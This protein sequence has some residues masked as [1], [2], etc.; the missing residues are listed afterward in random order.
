MVRIAC[1]AILFDLDGVLIDSTPAVARVWTRWAKAH[2]FD[3]VEVVR[4]AHGR[5]S[6]STIREYL[7]NAA[8]EKENA[9]VE[10]AEL[11]DLEDVVA[12]AG[13]RQLLNSLPRDRWTIV[14]S[15]TRRLAEAR[16]GAAALPLPSRFVTAT[17]VEKG[18]PDPEPYL[19]AAA[20]LG[21]PPSECVVVEDAPSGVRAGKAAGARVIAVPTTAQ[22]E[23][24][25]EAGAEWMVEAVSSISLL[26]PEADGRLQLSLSLLRD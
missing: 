11:E 20:L 7:P 16:L 15:G 25:R 4:S 21:F 24:L 10:R 12:F 17:D 19:K 14:T 13:V 1:D 23:E 5:P 18:K 26:S 22:E 6:I 3:P 2:D 9:M 8:H